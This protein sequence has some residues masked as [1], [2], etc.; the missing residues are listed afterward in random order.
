MSSSVLEFD[1]YRWILL[2]SLQVRLATKRAS[3][4][5][6]K[7]RIKMAPS[8]SNGGVGWLYLRDYRVSQALAG[9]IFRGSSTFPAF[10]LRSADHAT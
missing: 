7:G 3:G 2:P 4:T 6:A 1:D 10:T 8:S 9:R 5:R